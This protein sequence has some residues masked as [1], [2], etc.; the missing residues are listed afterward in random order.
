VIK[1]IMAAAV[2]IARGQRSC[3]ML[4]DVH[5]RRDWGWSPEYADALWRMRQQSIGSDFAIATG[6][7]HPPDEFAETAFGQVGLDWC[8][9]ADLLEAL[10]R[11]SRLAKRLGDPSGGREVLCWSLTYRTSD[12]VRLMVEAELAEAEGR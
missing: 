10:R 6:E 9:R 8:E 3:L 1:K 11:R 4:R 12:V 2:P 5:I 7:S